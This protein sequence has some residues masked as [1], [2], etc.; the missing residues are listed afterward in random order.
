MSA[1]KV[2][3]TK[4]GSIGWQ[5]FL[6][7]KKE[8]L[9]QFDH[10]KELCANRPTKTEYGNI[11]EAIF[12]KWL[13]EFLPKKYGIT[14]G[15][16]I[17]DIRSFDYVLRHY[18]LIIYDKINSPILWGTPDPDKSDQGK[19]RAIPADYVHAVLEIKSTLNRQSI[20]D[21]KKKLKEINIYKGH[22]KETFFAGIVFFE[23]KSSEQRSCKVA[24][25][26][27]D[28]DILGYFGGLI[29][30]AEGHDENITGYYHLLPGTETVEAMPLVR[31]IGGLEIDDKGNPVLTKQGD[32]CQAI[33]KDNIWHFDKG[34]SPNIEN[35]HL[36]WSYNSFPQ[37]TFD[38][39]ARLNGT[40]E[41]GKYSSSYG[42]SFFR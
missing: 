36:D 29:I 26:L 10:A 17:P 11:G 18:D 13:S 35:I 7:Q 34:Y 20:K 12:R 25:D 14:S 40:Y 32:T 6:S 16:I 15:F 1:R 33:P 38:I 39:L 8:I 5:E 37:F 27:Y 41:L 9:R 3:T 30:R 23:V 42:M 19:I 31:E 2:L 22:L 21:A 28:G 24:V 4:Y